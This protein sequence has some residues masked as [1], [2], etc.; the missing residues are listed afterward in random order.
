MAT[1]NKPTKAK[2]KPTKAVKEIKEKP[3]TEDQFKAKCTFDN[4]MI[5]FPILKE[6][7]YKMYLALWE[8]N[9]N[10][11]NSIFKEKD[12]TLKPLNDREITELIGA[13]MRITK[14]EKSNLFG[15]ELPEALEILRKEKSVIKKY[16]ESTKM[17]V[18]I[19]ITT[20]KKTTENNVSA[21]KVG[22]ALKSVLKTAGLSWW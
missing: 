18:K 7:T 20:T 13:Y 1:N 15:V 19:D 14:G 8:F 12:I 5:A 16:L 6:D 22:N 21:E 2:T 3:L 17:D 10:L 4:K 11:A 9:Q